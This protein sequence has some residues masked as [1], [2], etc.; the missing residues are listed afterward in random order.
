MIFASIPQAIPYSSGGGPDRIRPAPQQVTGRA[1]SDEAISPEPGAATGLSWLTKVD[2]L[3]PAAAARRQGY[4]DHHNL[5]IT[6]DIAKQTG[7]QSVSPGPQARVFR[8]FQPEAVTVMPALSA[9]GPFTIGEFG[10]GNVPATVPVRQ[11]WREKGQHSQTFVPP[12]EALWGEWNITPATPDSRLWSP[13]RTHDRH[14]FEPS[15]QAPAQVPPMLPF[16]QGGPPMPIKQSRPVP[17]ADGLKPAPPPEGDLY[18]AVLQD[19][20]AVPD[21]WRQRPRLIGP[22]EA[23]PP[24]AVDF[25][26]LAWLGAPAPRPRTPA[27]G[28]RDLSQAS[29]PRLEPDPLPASWATVSPGPQAGAFRPVRPEPPASKD[30][31][32]YWTLTTDSLAAAWSTQAF[33]GFARVQPVRPDARPD[34]PVLY[35]VE[36]G[37]LLTWA[38]TPQ[39]PVRVTP[40]VARHT[41]ATTQIDPFW[42]S[43]VVVA[44]PYYVVTGQ[45]FVAGAIEGDLSTQ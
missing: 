40:S 17:S 24:T 6:L 44:G 45:I 31:V 12:Y 41:P 18:A 29:P 28:P 7:W 4:S 25:Y 10:Q 11:P 43:L 38:T 3:P 30:A 21:R 39:L 35:D 22:Q 36:T 32:Q 16:E 13:R 37:F 27:A 5:V 23:P 34:R 42:G 26:L 1:S 14:G 9:I 33:A 19:R 2:A 8:P 15:V 20:P